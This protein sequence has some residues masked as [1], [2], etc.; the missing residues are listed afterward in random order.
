MLATGSVLERKEELLT[1]IEAMQPLLNE[2]AIAL[3]H[4]RLYRE[5]KEGQ[6]RIRQSQK[7]E[8]IGQL[9]AC[10]PTQFLSGAL[11]LLYIAPSPPVGSALC[12]IFCRRSR[13][14]S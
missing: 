4:A 14:T 10:V 7:M 9:P 6:E 2:V 1:R 8:A 11:P 5:I 3:E 13:P 12:L